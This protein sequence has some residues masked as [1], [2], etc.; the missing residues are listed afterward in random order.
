MIFH[1]DDRLDSTTH[2]SSVVIS[3]SSCVASVAMAIRVAM[4]VDGT[5]DS[6]DFQHNAILADRDY[7]EIWG[8]PPGSFFFKT[9]DRQNMIP[10]PTAR[11]L[12]VSM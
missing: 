4:A 11:T 1:V 12:N 5:E 2:S 9:K 8:P 3:L 7:S 10:A 6:V